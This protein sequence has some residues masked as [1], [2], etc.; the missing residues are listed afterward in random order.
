MKEYTRIGE[1]MQEGIALIGDGWL[2]DARDGFFE[3]DRRKA[4]INAY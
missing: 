4:R 2:G 3:A 1:N